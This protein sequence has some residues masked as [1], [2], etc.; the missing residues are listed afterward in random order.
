MQTRLFQWLVLLLFCISLLCLMGATTVPPKE[1]LSISSMVD[2][3][4]LAFTGE[5]VGMEFVFREDLPPQFTTDITVEV[6]EMIKGKP[7]AGENRVKFMIPGGEGVHPKTGE[8]LICVVPEA[9]QFEIGEKVFI[10]LRRHK[11][12]NR[13]PVPYGGL[14]TGGWG[15]RGIVDEKVSVPY[16]FKKRLFDNGQW[17]NETWVRDIR[18]PIALAKQMAQ[19]ALRDAEAVSAIEE[20]MRT[21]AKEAP[22]VPGERPI[23]GQALLDGVAA[24]ISPILTREQMEGR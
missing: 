21:F 13:L 7:N 5:V 24:E 19:A 17:R 11:R 18:L 12:L 4:V 8:A 2:I 10:F 20:R 3:S 23:P 6:E 9:P 1:G 15:K 16:T 14:I 22:V